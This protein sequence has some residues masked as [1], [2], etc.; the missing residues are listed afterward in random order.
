MAKKRYPLESIKDALGGDFSKGI[1]KKLMIDTL[2][3]A[4]DYLTGRMIEVFGD[5]KKILRWFYGKSMA[6]G[7]VSPY[8]MCKDEKKSEIKDELDRIDYGDF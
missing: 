7:N 1:E 5:N 6:S 3:V 4:G 8:Q 2:S